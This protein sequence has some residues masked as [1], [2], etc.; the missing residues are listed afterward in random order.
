MKPCKYFYTLEPIDWFAGFLTVGEYIKK[1]GDESIDMSTT[2]NII[3]QTDEFIKWLVETAYELKNHCSSWEGDIRDRVYIF[4][5][6][7]GEPGNP[8]PLA[9]I[10]KQDN[11]GTTFIASPHNLMWLSE[12]RQ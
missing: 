11:N 9:L 4:S 1:L 2:G 5:L 10:V 3:F 8:E 12:G 6:P 7:D